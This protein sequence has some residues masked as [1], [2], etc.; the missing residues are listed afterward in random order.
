M[1]LFS[2]LMTSPGEQDR[3][4]LQRFEPWSSATHNQPLLF[5]K[6]EVTGLGSA[7]S[8][9]F[10]LINRSL[11]EWACIVNGL[12]LLGPRYL[13]RHR[14]IESHYGL[15]NK[16]STEGFPALPPSGQTAASTWLRELDL[17]STS[18]YG[19]HEYLQE[20]P[21]ASARELLTS[22]EEAHH[23]A[24]LAGGA[25]VS[26]YET[27]GRRI[28]IINGFHP[29][30]LDHFY[31]ASSPIVVATLKTSTGWRDLRSSL[32]GVTDPSKAAR[33][34]LREQFRSRG[35]ELGL[36]GI[37][38]MRNGVHI[39]AGPVEAAIE[40]QRYFG[41]HDADGSLEIA[42]TNLGSLLIAEEGHDRANEL[43][44]NRDISVDGRRG[45]V[46]DLTEE[47]DTSE[48]LA[49]LKRAELT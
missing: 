24:R 8:P 45:S 34:S 48:A 38:S 49:L 5:I 47:L 25:Y 11:E 28:G 3:L 7:A 27:Q 2:A 17:T 10:D 4:V 43:I 37:N 14:L 41:D 23:P 26:L 35:V 32:V 42:A 30:Q 16:Y 31:S 39:S 12:Y 40:V 20:H 19:A 36:G 18:I 21:D 33:G 15:I 44:S 29:A 13:A 22:H 1:D 46:F 6:P 9:A